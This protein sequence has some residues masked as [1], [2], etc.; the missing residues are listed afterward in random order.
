MVEQVTL[1]QSFPLRCCTIWSPGLG[2]AEVWWLAVKTAAS[3]YHRGDG[4]RLMGAFPTMRASMSWG[5]QADCWQATA[6]LT[7]QLSLKRLR[8][9]H[10]KG[11]H[12]DPLAFHHRKV[13]SPVRA[14]A[15]G[16]GDD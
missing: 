3:T 13:A 10:R 11:C 8:V 9:F 14:G 4:R 15:K 2:Q 16:G 1:L 7:M 5:V 12:A 6:L